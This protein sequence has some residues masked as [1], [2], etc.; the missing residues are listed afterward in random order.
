VR[1]GARLDGKDTNPEPPAEV[2]DRIRMAALTLFGQKGYASVS[3]RQVCKLASTTLPMVYYY[4]GSK[5][6]LYQAIW[7][8]AWQ[9]RRI[10]LKRALRCEGAPLDRL[11]RILEA[12]VGLGQEPVIRELQLFFLRELFG[13]GS[14]M[15]KQS[16]DSSDRQFRHALKQVIQDGIEA[17]VFRPVKVEMAVLAITGIVNTF[18]RRIALGAPLSLEDGIEQVTDTF[19]HGLLR[20]DSVTNYGFAD[21][22]K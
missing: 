19:V 3:V 15:Y 9:E 8:E 14:D 13:L 2:K 20:G 11:Q 18:S 22:Q 17:G 12:W 16:V 1:R 5:R 10:G 7:G 6:G 21:G 4:Y